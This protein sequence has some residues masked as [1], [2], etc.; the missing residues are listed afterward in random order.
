MSRILVLSIAY[1]FESIRAI[2]ILIHLLCNYT[3]SMLMCIIGFYHAFFVV[4]D[5]SMVFF[6]RLGTSAIWLFF[7]KVCSCISKFW[8]T[9]AFDFL[10]R[11]C[12]L[13]NKC[14]WI[15][16]RYRQKE[17]D[18]FT[19]LLCDNTSIWFDFLLWGMKIESS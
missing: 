12:K 17:L 10:Y 7:I 2:S 18:M 14:S 15:A 19:T 1:M 5:I 13:K 3:W 6:S 16:T 9:L 8:N 11:A 4:E